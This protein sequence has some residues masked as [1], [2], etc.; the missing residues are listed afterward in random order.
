MVV[1]VGRLILTDGRAAAGFFPSELVHLFGLDH[2][3][4]ASQP[5]S[6][7]LFHPYVCSDRRCEVQ[8]LYVS[9]AVDGRVHV[10]P[11]CLPLARCSLFLESFIEVSASAERRSRLIRSSAPY[12]CLRRRCLRCGISRHGVPW[13]S[14]RL[15][16]MNAELSPCSGRAHSMS[17]IGQLPDGVSLLYVSQLGAIYHRKDFIPP[18]HTSIAHTNDRTKPSTRP[19]LPMHNKTDN[20]QCWSASHE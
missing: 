11:R 3:W 17:R 5:L 19:Q 15:R 2:T 1:V 18:Q 14:P 16:C 12:R 6:T 20:G 7:S 10:T 4:C 9:S 8:A 13:T